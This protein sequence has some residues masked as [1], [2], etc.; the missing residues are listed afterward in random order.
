MKK[1]FTCPYCYGEHDWETCVK[2]ESETNWE[3]YC[4]VVKREIPVEFLAIKTKAKIALVGARY[5]GKS[6]YI[7]V[8]VNEI[9]KKMAPSFN[10]I[11]SKRTSE[12]S[13]YFYDSYYYDRLYKW[14]RVMPCGAKCFQ[15]SM[16]FPLSFLTRRNRIKQT[17]WLTFH[18]DNY[19][20]G[21]WYDDEETELL[22]SY[23]SN[24]NGI[25]F[26]LDPLQVPAIREK[27][28]GRIYLPYENQDGVELLERLIRALRENQKIKPNKQINTPLAIVFTKMDVLYNHK[29]LFPAETLGKESEH[30][31]RG[32]FVESDHK[33]V[34][35]EIRD[36]LENWGDG[37]LKQLLHNFSNYAFFGVSA[38]GNE[39]V[40]GN[41]PNGIQPKRVLDPLLWLLAEKKLIKRVKK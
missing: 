27:L 14:K 15:A 37:E 4:P 41:I 33:E 31:S 30:L 9:Q 1:K 7:G 2:Q 24:A 32:V 22:D 26:L 3:V 28:E 20:S 10:C 36:L 8:L 23:L 6:N 38:L 34:E 12:E 5:T 16:I 18:D 17:A 29:D 21:S 11:F 13:A 40:G 19:V 25:I 39:P 35:L